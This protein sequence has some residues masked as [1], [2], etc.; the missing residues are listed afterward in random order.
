MSCDRKFKV[1]CLH[2]HPGNSAA[3]QIFVKHFQSQGIDAVAI[4]LRGYGNHRTN[5]E[6]A[7]SDHIQDIWEVLKNESAHDLTDYLILGWSLGGI[8]AIETALRDGAIAN[9]LTQNIRIVGLVLIATAAKPRSN[10]PKIAWWEY[11][12]L[13]IAVALHRLIPQQNWHIELFGKRSL[14]K[15]LIQQHHRAAYD[16]IAYTGAKAYVQTSGYAQRA[17]ATALRQGYDRTADL[18]KITIPCLAIA[19]AE[20]RHITAAS[21]EETAK[22]LPNCE[23]ICYPNT[24]HLLPWE[25]CDRILSDI[26]QWCDRQGWTA[27]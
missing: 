19:A 13:A 15:Y 2:G 21:T 22:L 18:G 8:L 11:A 7:M 25:I 10:L 4:D 3:M 20:D 5:A 23:F 16:Q 17:L 9:N 6:F 26:S 24:A 1:L 27:K 14:I 12:N